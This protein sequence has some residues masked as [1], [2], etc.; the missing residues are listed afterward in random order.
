[1]TGDCTGIWVIPD[2][3]RWDMRQ[4]VTVKFCDLLIDLH[5]ASAQLVLVSQHFRESN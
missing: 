1:M 2:A 5:L 4:G 3:T